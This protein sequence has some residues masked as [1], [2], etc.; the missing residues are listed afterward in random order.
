MDAEYTDER[1]LRD[2]LFAPSRLR[3]ILVRFAVSLE[4][5]QLAL[6]SLHRH[7]EESAR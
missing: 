1:S 5:L 4:F 6:H 7:N 3:S 2:I